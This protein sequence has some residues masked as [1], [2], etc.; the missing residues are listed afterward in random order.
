MS[1]RLQ[2]VTTP[3]FHRGQTGATVR[4]QRK[5]KNKEI[6]QSFYLARPTFFNKLTQTQKLLHVLNKKIQ[7]IN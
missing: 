5:K 7:I 3:K 4:A 2:S 1:S 6:L